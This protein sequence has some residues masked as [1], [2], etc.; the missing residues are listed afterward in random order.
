LQALTGSE[1]ASLVDAVKT[2]R[3]KNAA[4]L[5]VADRRGVEMAATLSYFCHPA[6]D[7]IALGAPLLHRARYGAREVNR[8]IK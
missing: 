1:D 3:S 7:P 8:V 5:G 6:T 2:A 4:D